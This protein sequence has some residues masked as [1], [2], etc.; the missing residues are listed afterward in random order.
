LDDKILKLVQIAKKGNFLVFGKEGIRKYINSALC[1][2][3][4]VMA[5]DVSDKIL[6][7]YKRRAKNSNVDIVILGKYSKNDIGRAIG[8]DQISVI[9]INEKNLAFEIKR[10]IKATRR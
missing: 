5:N 3:V 8:K 7:D 2:K 4:L 9:G 1:D 10:I 6:C